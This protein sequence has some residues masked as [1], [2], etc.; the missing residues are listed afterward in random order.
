MTL[1][2]PVDAKL[3]GDTVRGKIVNDYVVVADP[4]LLAERFANWSSTP[5]AILNFTRKYGPLKSDSIVKGQYTVDRGEWCRW[6]KSFQ[7]SWRMISP[8]NLPTADSIGVSHHS[9]LFRQIRLSEGSFLRFHHSG[10]ALLVKDMWTLI[11]VCFCAIPIERLRVCTARDCAKPYFVAH[12]LKQTLCGAALCK[13][14]NERRLKREWFEREK[15]P[16]LAERK[17]IRKGE[18]DGTQE[19]R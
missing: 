2:K 5:Q 1:A 17:R 16:I 11:D 14:W 6:Q 19:T 7:D 12:H 3:V 15:G 9:D 8:A 13:G 10:A 4:I 18:K